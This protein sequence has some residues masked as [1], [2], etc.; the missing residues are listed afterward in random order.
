MSGASANEPPQAERKPFS[1]DYLDYWAPLP[2][3]EAEN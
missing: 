2:D 3:L 1:R